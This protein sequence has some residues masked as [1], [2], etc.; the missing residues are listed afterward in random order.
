MAL[1]DPTPWAGFIATYGAPNIG[2]IGSFH[3]YPR[4]LLNRRLRMVNGLHDPQYLAAEIRLYVDQLK[5]LGVDVA[6]GIY[7]TGHEFEFFPEEEGRSL[8]FIAHTVRDPLPSH[9]VWETSNPAVGRCDWVRIDAVGDVGNNGDI[10]DINLLYRSAQ[11]LLGV[12]IETYTADGG[13]VADIFPGFV[14]HSAGVQVGDLLVQANDQASTSSSDIQLAM[15]GKS[16][17]DVIHIT[18]VQNGET[19]ALSAAVPEPFPIYPR[20]MMSGVLDVVADGNRIELSARHVK[21]YTLYLSSQQFD[22]GQ[23]I[24]AITNGQLSFLDTVS[25]NIRFMLEQAATDLDRQTVY[26][27]Q[28]GIHVKSSD[29]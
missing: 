19:L 26:E 18:V 29:S 9:V 10:P 4:N 1:Q 16:P 14:A 24:E 28:L 12:N 17:G 6:W 21:S 13:M 23:P 15:E 2:A 27:A 7:P 20:L 5:N 8:E 25:P 22:L 11:I 3:A